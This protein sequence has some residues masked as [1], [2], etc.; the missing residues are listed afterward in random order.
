MAKLYF[1]KKYHDN[2]RHWSQF[3]LQ[4]Y[5][6]GVLAF[7]SLHCIVH[8]SFTSH[9]DSFLGPA[10]HRYQSCV[11]FRSWSLALSFIDFVHSLVT[12]VAADALGPQHPAAGRRDDDVDDH[13]DGNADRHLCRKEEKLRKGIDH[14]IH[15]HKQVLKKRL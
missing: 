8:T 15:G 1:T 14:L 7:D 4:S 6:N 13:N 9:S 10:S 3:L 5:M 2:G 11:H 12:V